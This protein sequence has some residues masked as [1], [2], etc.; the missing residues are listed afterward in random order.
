MPLFE[1]K[2]QRKDGGLVAQMNFLE[3]SEEYL[4]TKPYSMRYEPENGIPQSIV[5]YEKHEVTIHN[6]RR[7]K[8]RLN[9]ASCGFGVMSMETELNYDDFADC[10]KIESIYLEEVRD[11]LQQ[12][13][14]A[15]YVY[16][17]DYVVCFIII[18]ERQ[19]AQPPSDQVR[20][21]HQSFPISTGEEYE[22]QQ[23]TTLAH[24]GQS[25]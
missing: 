4:E 13:F 8:E 24:I 9:F 23:P 20:R 11:K 10:K 18:T 12:G 21:R 6:L 25:S 1:S 14:N 22:Y 17:M 3:R 5:K 16:I 7:C 2:D 19:I 15:S